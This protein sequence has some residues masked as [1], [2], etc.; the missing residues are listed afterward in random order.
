MEKTSRYPNFEQISI[1][2]AS[3]LLSFAAARFVN[4]EGKIIPLEFMG[5][6]FIVQLNA[7]TLISIVIMGITAAGTDWMLRN[8]PSLKKKRTL[9]HWI[10]PALTTLAI[11]IPLNNFPIGT[12]WWLGF[13]L[14]GVL[15]YLVLLAEY[16]TVDENDPRYLLASLGLIVLSYSLFLILLISIDTIG[17][18]LL[19][20]IPT[21]GISSFL[22]VLRSNRLQLGEWKSPLA[23]LVS[24]ITMQIT[25]AFH[26]FPI[27][28]MAFGLIILAITY[29]LTSFIISK[30][31]NRRFQP[32]L[33]EAGIIFGLLVI[34]AFWLS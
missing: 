13:F 29:S 6:L 20:A 24:V 4:L 26:Y 19:V 16:I 11:S 3:I 7:K 18:R 25:A 27:S 17:V 34:L 22:V 5:V 15:L 21:V 28:P 1:L 8:H 9:S 2:I 14:G 12:L 33:V 23:L 30:E 10:T 31:Q 32:S